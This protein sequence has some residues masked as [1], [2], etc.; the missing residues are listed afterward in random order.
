MKYEVSVHLFRDRHDRCVDAQF[1]VRAQDTRAL[2]PDGLNV[3]EICVVACPPASAAV[4]FHCPPIGRRADDEIDRMSGKSA[5]T[6]A[7]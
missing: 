6:R 4:V 2:V 5:M 3:I 7:A 1:P